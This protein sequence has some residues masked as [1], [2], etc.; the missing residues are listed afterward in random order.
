MVKFSHMEDR[1]SVEKLRGKLMQIATDDAVGVSCN[2]QIP[3]SCIHSNPFWGP[4]AP[5]QEKTV[6][7]K[8][9]LFRGDLGAMVARY[10]RDF[11]MVCGQFGGG[12]DPRS[13]ATI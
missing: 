12:L 8:I 3:M 6:H 4:L 9:Y 13:S 7:G 1:A 2:H 5:G 11:G 10:R